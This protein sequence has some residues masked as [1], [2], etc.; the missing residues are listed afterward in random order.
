MGWVR[1]D[2]PFAGFNPAGLA[3]FF[4]AQFAVFGPILFAT[5]LWAAATGREAR[6]LVFALPPVALVCMQAFLDRAYANWAA[7]AYFGGTVLVVGVLLA[8]PRLLLL[9]LVLNGAVALALPALTLVPEVRLGGDAPVLKRYLG[10]EALSLQILSLARDAGNV[11]IVAERRD[12]LADLFYTGRDA[13]LA[14]YAPRP[15]GRPQDHYAQTYPL[16]ATLSGP[17]LF[18]GEAAPACPTLGPVLPLDTAGGGYDG[19]ALSAWLVD[20]ECLR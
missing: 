2:A 16:P 1:E 17:V 20:A 6:L 3:E 8:R 18:V 19:L 7:A 14:I 12:V 4:L 11:P 13:G 15:V 10:R 5:L 9:S